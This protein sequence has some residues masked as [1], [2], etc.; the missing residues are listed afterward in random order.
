VINAGHVFGG[1]LLERAPLEDMPTIK[2]ITNQKLASHYSSGENNPYTQRKER[3]KESFENPE[4][5]G[6]RYIRINEHEKWLYSIMR[7]LNNIT[8][9]QN[10][11]IE[12]L[13]ITSDTI[14]I[15]YSASSGTNNLNDPTAIY[16]CDNNL[17]IN[18][19][20]PSMFLGEPQEI[21]AAHVTD[22]VN[23]RA[24]F[25]EAKFSSIIRTIKLFTS[26]GNIGEHD[27]LKILGYFAVLESLLS[28]APKSNESADSITRQLKRNLLLLDNRLRLHGSDFGFDSFTSSKPETVIGKLYSI[29]SSI[30]HGNDP[31][32]VV[33][34]FSENA[35]SRNGVTWM[36]HISLYLFTIV[37]KTLQCALREPQLITD[38]KG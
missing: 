30:A 2:N 18:P 28:H 23:L 16:G 24:F 38:L 36:N 14:R 31:K 7:P 8:L 15:C 29:R 12:A 11:L 6:Y 32:D 1:W 21:N 26:M 5:H 34:W 17:V 37:Q 22:I 19:A 3:N 4:G 25:D 27:E 35:G 33:C 9:N 10:Q 20:Y 13:F